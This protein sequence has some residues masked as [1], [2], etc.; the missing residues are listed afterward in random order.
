MAT[1]KQ[2]PSGAYRTLVYS[3]T[4]KVDGKDK[5]IYESFTSW[6]KDESALMAA[7]FKVT[8][9]KK[10]P[11][12]KL[13]M[14]VG[15]TIDRYIENKELLSPTTISTYKLIREFAFQDIMNMAIKEL[16]DDIM[17]ESINKE[18]KRKAQGRNGNRVLSPKTVANE[19][20]LLST[21][22]KKYHKLVFDITLPKKIV[23]NIEYPEPS[24]IINIIKGTSIELPCML[25]IWLSFS[26]SEIRGLKCSSVKDGVICVDQVLV[27][28][29][30]ESV[31]KQ[32]GKAE[33]RIRKHRLPKY[34]INLIEQQDTY[35]KYMESGEDCLLIP[36]T[37]SQLY[38]RYKRILD[39]HNINIT[40]HALR[41]LNAS[42]MLSLGIPDKYA[43]ERG[44]WKTPHT[45]KKVYQHTFS[46]ERT[47]VDDKIDD[48]FNKLV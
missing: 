48:Y 5:R 1:P 34:I 44:G 6:D 26:M 43:M 36:L 30:N 20:G 39:K 17:Q 46:A 18:S 24:V 3:H 15:E 12:S 35:K 10:K 28:V 22:I 21:A 47:I 42:V 45:M 7:E 27:D 31:V 23:K 32:T 38:K 4:E 2:L 13:N 25:S 11:D 37:S 14:T 29:G 9:K 40:F 8:K 16:D 19:Y 41:H 33:K